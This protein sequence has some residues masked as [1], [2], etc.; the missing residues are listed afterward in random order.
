MVSYKVDITNSARKEIKKLD[1]QI[2]PKITEKIEALAN[3]PLPSGCKR[4][5]A[6]NGYRIRVGDYRIIYD[7]DI[8]NQL[9]KIYKVGHR[10]DVY[11]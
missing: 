11:N 8:Q 7:I 3:N 1:F 5:I 6:R 10:K 9:V 2:V 4:L